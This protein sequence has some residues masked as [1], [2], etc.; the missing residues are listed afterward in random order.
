MD[1]KTMGWI[2]IG[3]GVLALL[4]SGRIGYSGMMGMMGFGTGYNMMSYGSGLAVT[5]LAIALIIVG[6]HQVMDEK[7]HK[8]R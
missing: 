5:I 8:K 6:V 2:Q 7:Q 4:F 3:G 1:T